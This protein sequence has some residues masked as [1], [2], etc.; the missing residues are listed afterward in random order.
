MQFSSLPIRVDLQATLEARSFSTATPIQ[1]EAIPVALQGKDLLGQAR[2]GTGKTLAFALPIAQRLEPHSERGRAPRALILAPTRELALQVAKE[3]E[4]IA[5]RLKIVAVYGGTGYTQQA[6]A[7]KRGCDIVVATPGRA[8]DYL[9][10]RVLDLSKIEVA[11]LDEADE[12]LSMGFEE[13]VERILEATPTSRQTLLFSATV[14]AWAKRL[15]ERYLN[16][17]V[18]INVVKNESIS[19]EEQ[20]LFAP[21]QNRLT[22]LTSLIYAY[23]PERTIVFTQTKAEVDELAL[24][25]QSRGLIADP[26]HGDMNQRERELVMGRFR[27][28]QASVLVATD[29][30]ARG[31][32]IPEVDLVVHY[33][34]PEKAE[35]YQHRSGRTGRAGRSGKVVLMFSSR[36]RRELGE[37]ERLVNRKFRHIQA[38]SSQDVQDSKW[39]RL[40]ARLE[41]VSEADRNLWR[42]YAERLHDTP[43]ALAALLSLLLG[44]APAPRSLLT[45]QEGWVTMKL[46]GPRLSVPR[47]VAM[48]KKAGAGEIGRIH[49]EDDSTAFFDLRIEE[50]E[51]VQVREL[52]GME[53]GK[54]E[55]V[56]P[57]SQNTPE[58]SSAPR[59]SNTFRGRRREEDNFINGH[60]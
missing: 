26:I 45:H 29:V 17:P 10:Q 50:V 54:A 28:G 13:D 58:R 41:T 7:L 33:R 53:F 21:L 34:L 1:A 12:M 27:A 44:G 23:D 14:P 48:L 16:N 36:E 42:S 15:S 24:G 52:R 18:H 37:L 25:L 57:S 4:W 20:A 22:T 9:G 6:I 51:R 30:A 19:Y 11:V 47:V 2:T 46:E 60:S 5:P 3:L 31:L 35:A 49:L 39:R 38:P 8:I 55:S 43:E 59:N 32:D 40:Q 56:P